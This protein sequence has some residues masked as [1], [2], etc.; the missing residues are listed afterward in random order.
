MSAPSR[1][2]ARVVLSLPEGGV[3]PEVEAAMRSALSAHD[4]R[5]PPPRAPSPVAAVERSAF[6][7]AVDAMLDADVLV[8]EASRPSH[9]VGWDVA[10]FLAKGRLVVVCCERDARG[11]LS[12]MLAGNP[13]PWSRLVLYDSPRGLEAALRATVTPNG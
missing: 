7:G 6:L 4:L 8:A 9:A 2:V 12:P 5:A 3:S 10:W 11:M 1:R 13:S